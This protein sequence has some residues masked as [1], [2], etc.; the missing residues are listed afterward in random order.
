M[1]SLCAD[2]PGPANVRAALVAAVTATV[3]GAVVL[4]GLR[5]LSSRLWPAAAPSG[6]FPRLPWPRGPA[7]EHVVFIVSLLIQTLTPSTLLSFQ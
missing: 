4:C 2:A 6:Q 7:E 1:A 5:E 3:S